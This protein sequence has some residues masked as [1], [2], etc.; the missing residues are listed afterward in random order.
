MSQV[1]DTLP[2]NAGPAE[3]LQEMVDKISLLSAY[4]AAGCLGLLT[5]L[6][7]GQV[8]CGLL[9][10]VFDGFP[11]DI[12]V[13]WEYSAYLMGTAFMLGGG[14]TLRAGM[15]IRVELLLRAF[16]GRFLRPLEFLAAFMGAAF[17][18][19][20]AWSLGKFAMASWSTGAVSG[21]SLT[22]L[23]I[24]QAAL[25]V[26]TTV[27]ALQSIMQVIACMLDKP[28]INESFKVAGTTE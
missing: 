20:L 27:Y 12:A 1:T 14:L 22:P 11:S 17:V 7:L 26:G 23:W 15:Q 21:E 19:F 9:S 8:A 24:P 6:T 28:L 2:P 16:G 5:L 10:K 13:G 25:T 4:L 18:S 3:K